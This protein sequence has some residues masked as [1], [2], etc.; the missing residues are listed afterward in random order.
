VYEIKSLFQTVQYMSLNQDS[1]HQW[2]LA[3][4]RTSRLCS[5]D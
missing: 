5:M 1:G 3:F 2:C 4:Y